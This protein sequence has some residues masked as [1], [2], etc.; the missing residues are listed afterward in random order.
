[1][2]KSR[3]PE[4]SFFVAP[5]YLHG[6]GFHHWGVIVGYT[7][8]ALSSPIQVSANYLRLSGAG[9]NYRYGIDAKVAHTFGPVTGPVVASLGH[10]EDVGNDTTVT[11]ALDVALGRYLLAVANYGY[12]RFDPEGGRAFSRYGPRHRSRVPGTE[13]RVAHR[14]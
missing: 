3:G 4:R 10:F 7:N 1:L 9:F 11:A 5:G 8:H 14:R 13:H 2:T 12:S 6:E